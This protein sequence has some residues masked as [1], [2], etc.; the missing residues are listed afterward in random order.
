MK[1][2]RLAL[3]TFAF[4]SLTVLNF[5]QSECCFVNGS[6]ASSDE[7]SSDETSSTST[8]STSSSVDHTQGSGLANKYCPIWNVSYTINGSLTP[9]TSVTCS[10][11][12]KYKCEAGTCP[13]GV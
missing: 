12:G 4:V 7:S 10:T 9:S 2:F 11:G 6:L 5:T 8:T 1:K 13:H 3:G